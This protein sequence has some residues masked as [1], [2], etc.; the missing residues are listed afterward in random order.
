MIPQ[1]VVFS[2]TFLKTGFI[3]ELI[4]LFFASVADGTPVQG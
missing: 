4:Q 1:N 3:I 2:Y